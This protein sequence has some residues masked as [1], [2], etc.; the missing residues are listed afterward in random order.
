MDTDTCGQGAVNSHVAMSIEQPGSG[1]RSSLWASPIARNQVA[2]HRP[3]L[4]FGRNLRVCLSVS[5]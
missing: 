5:H 4:S 2:C 1:R 3:F